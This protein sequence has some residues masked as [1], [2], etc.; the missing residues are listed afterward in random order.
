MTDFIKLTA[1]NDKPVYLRRDAVIRVL[2]RSES[3]S[4]VTS[5]LLSSGA[6]QGVHETPEQVL[7]LLA[8]GNYPP[9]DIPI[10]GEVEQL[11]P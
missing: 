9:P 6:E 5:V 2:A 11:D 8:G 3:P 1:P 10:P 7:A 4:A